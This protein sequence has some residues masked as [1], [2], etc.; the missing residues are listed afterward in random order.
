MAY[1]ATY[2]ADDLGAITIDGV[3]SVFAAIVGL[4]TIVGLVLLWVFLRKRMK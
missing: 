1:N 2:T 4:A 3:A